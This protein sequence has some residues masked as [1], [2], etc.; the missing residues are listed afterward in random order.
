MRAEQ[1]KT[2]KH[3][4]M[5]STSFAVMAVLVAR[6]DAGTPSRRKDTTPPTI[7]IAV[8][9]LDGSARSTDGWYHSSVRVTFK[10]AD[11]GGSGLASCPA[12]LTVSMQ[13]ANQLVSG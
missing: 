5:T 9:A 4:L 2:T 11:T 1:R 13:G 7:I 10:C 6:L 3:R 8:T 12:A